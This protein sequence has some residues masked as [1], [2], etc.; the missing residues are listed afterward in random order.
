ML[1]SLSKKFVFVANLKTA[2]TSIEKALRPYAEVALVESRFGK[3]QPFRTIEARFAWLLGLID[4]N[5]LL[6]FGVMRDPV[7]YMISLYNSHTDA[8]FKDNPALYT[9]G[10]DFDRFLGEWT[11]RNE[12]Q[13]RQQYLR[14]LDANGRIAANYIISYDRLEAGLRF[15]GQRIGAKSPLL[16]GRENASPGSFEAA[17]L[18]PAQHRWIETHFAQ[19]RDVLNDYCDRLLTGRPQF[20]PGDAEAKQ[21]VAAIDAVAA[22]DQT[23]A[24][25]TA[26]ER[27]VAPAVSVDA[28]TAAARRPQAE[29]I[30]QALYRVLLLREPDMAGGDARIAQLAAGRPVEDVIRQMLAS[31]EFAAKRSWFLRTYLAAAGSTA[32]REPAPPAPRPDAGSPAPQTAP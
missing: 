28:E 1:I 2:S 19:D 10:L 17:A 6:V 13:V 24:H 20:A 7:D 31:Q 18:T 32:G 25:Q 12:E 29:K 15:V 8:K 27:A 26:G 14:F 30:V 16:L 4:P 11:A 9:A 3:H 21:P 22:A 5:E 23:A